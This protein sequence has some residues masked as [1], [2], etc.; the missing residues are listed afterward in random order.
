MVIPYHTNGYLIVGK[1]AIMA[2]RRRLSQLPQT[3][4]LNPDWHWA[5]RQGSAD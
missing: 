1:L 5:S 3:A 4:E 2:E